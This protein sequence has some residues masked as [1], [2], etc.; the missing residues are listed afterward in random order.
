MTLN[1]LAVLNDITV[2][3]ALNKLNETGEGFLCIIDKWNRLVGVLTDGDIRR[4]IIKNVPLDSGIETIVNH[5]CQTWSGKTGNEALSYMKAQKLRHMPVVDS[6]RMLIDV[7]LMDDINFRIKDNAVVL[8]VGGYGKRLK[9]LTDN[10]PKPMLPVGNKPF[11]HYG[12]EELASQGFHSFYRCV[13][14]LAEQIV[15][16]FGDGHK[17]GINIKYIIEKEPLGTAGALSLL[18]KGSLSMVVM[19]GDIMTKLCFDMVLNHHREQGNIATMCVS[20]YEHKIPY[21]VIEADG[22]EITAISEKPVNKYLIN[23]GVYILEPSCIDFIPHNTAYDL[24]SLFKKLISNGEKT[25]IFP[26]QD[27]WLDIG[28]HDDYQKAQLLR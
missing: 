24:P 14:Y 7:I 16:Y 28:T 2:L 20:E 21:G 15:E 13:N 4:A 12:M 18:P 3:G 25:G 22:Y 6:N 8:M 17:L 5:N 1:R 26:L 19:N 27:Y 10:T 9:P 11:F 23:A